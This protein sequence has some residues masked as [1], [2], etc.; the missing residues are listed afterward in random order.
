MG[1]VSTWLLPTPEFFSLG[2]LITILTARARPR[3][4]DPQAHSRRQDSAHHHHHHHH[5]AVGVYVLGQ[6]STGKTLLMNALLCG[7]EDTGSCVVGRW[8]GHMRASAASVQ[9][10]LENILHPRS[11]GDLVRD[12]KARG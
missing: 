7:L 3:S 4:F 6:A 9:S 5:H 1:C 11:S 8:N 2:F 12:T 10:T